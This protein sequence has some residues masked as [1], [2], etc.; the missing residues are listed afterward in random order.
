MTGIE[1]LQHTMDVFPHA[2]CIVLTKYGDTE[3]TRSINKVKIDDY[4]TKPWDPP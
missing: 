2:K 4:L 1:F 3:A